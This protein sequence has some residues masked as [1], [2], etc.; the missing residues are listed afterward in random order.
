MHCIHTTLTPTPITM[1]KVVIGA[2]GNKC[3]NYGRCL[4]QVVV[5]MKVGEV[6]KAGEAIMKVGEVMVM[7]K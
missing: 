4:C 1:G 7:V 6:M 5:V 3:C 2:G